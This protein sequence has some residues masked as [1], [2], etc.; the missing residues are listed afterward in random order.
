MIAK[1]KMIDAAKEIIEQY[2]NTLVYIH[3]HD[4]LADQNI[5]H[6][7]FDNIPKILKKHGVEYA[8]GRRVIVNNKDKT[9]N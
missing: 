5:I 1:Q 2:E 3:C 9:V 8:S 7:C 6:E 4:K